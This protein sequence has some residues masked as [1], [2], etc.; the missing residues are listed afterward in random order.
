[1]ATMAGFAFAVALLCSGLS[2]ST[3]GTL[4]GQMVLEGFLK[5]EDNYD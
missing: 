4:A 5:K 1:M 3:T 2:S